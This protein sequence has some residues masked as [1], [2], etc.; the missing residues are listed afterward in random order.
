MHNVRLGRADPPV[1]LL[2]LGHQEEELRQRAGEE[3]RQGFEDPLPSVESLG[4][5]VE[6]RHVQPPEAVGADG[7]EAHGQHHAHQLGP[8]RRPV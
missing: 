3:Q 2:V 5:G 6:R 7:H 8:R 4:G 1:H